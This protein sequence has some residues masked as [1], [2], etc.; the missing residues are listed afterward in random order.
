M[1]VILILYIGAV[2]GYWLGYKTR[3]NQIR[4]V[5]LKILKDYES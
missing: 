5:N 1:N 4:T 2:F 3:D